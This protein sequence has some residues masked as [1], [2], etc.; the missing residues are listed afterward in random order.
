M[1]TEQ[2]QPEH[3]KWVFE[4]ERLDREYTFREKELLLR[5]RELANSRARITPALLTIMVT[6]IGILGTLIG[7]YV[8]GSSNQRLEKLKFESELITKVVTSG[9]LTQNKRNLKFLLD[10]GFISDP[11]HRISALVKDS[12]FGLQIQSQAEERSDG[13]LLGRVE[14]EDHRPVGGVWIQMRDDRSVY[15]RT[16]RMGNF[17]LHFPHHGP[18]LQIVFSKK[19]FIPYTF[20]GAVTNETQLE[21]IFKRQNLAAA[22]KL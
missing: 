12:A 11:D 17:C 5:E 2:T 21:L 8:Q 15:A 6:L 16:D 20:S 10:A 3:E 22:E 18:Q 14:D 19:G 7:S 4:R 1:G 13:F 9:D